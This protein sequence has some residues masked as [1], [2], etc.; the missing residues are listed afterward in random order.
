[1]SEQIAFRVAG[2]A[3]EHRVTSIVCLLRTALAQEAREGVAGRDG[4][5]LG[6]VDQWLNHVITRAIRLGYACGRLRHARAV[7]VDSFFGLATRLLQAV[8]FDRM[9]VVPGEVVDAE[10]INWKQ[11]VNDGLRAAPLRSHEKIP[12]PKGKPRFVEAQILDSDA[13]GLAAFCASEMYLQQDE[14]CYRVA[15]AAAEAALLATAV[16]LE[17]QVAVD[18]ETGKR[19]YLQIPGFPDLW[20]T[21]LE[22]VGSV[23]F[24]DAQRK[25]FIRFLTLTDAP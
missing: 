17:G 6:N 16:R 7:S 13:E 18:A 25:Q 15:D 24:N 3:L 4:G 1:M 23:K 21:L 14:W 19:H 9:A 5:P 10:G 22:V 12:Y 2:A 8:V 11:L 20:T